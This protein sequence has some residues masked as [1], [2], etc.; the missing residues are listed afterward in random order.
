MPAHQVEEFDQ[1]RKN[2]IGH[3]DSVDLLNQ[4]EKFTR[5]A[6]RGFSQ[7]HGKEMIKKSLFRNH[8]GS[9][10]NIDAKPDNE[11]SKAEQMVNTKTLF[12][13]MFSRFEK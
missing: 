13:A 4:K 1:D 3:R 12:K 6:N 7:I 8:D 2:E 5:R 9:S 11:V 10:K